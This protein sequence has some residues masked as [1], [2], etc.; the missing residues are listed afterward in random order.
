MRLAATSFAAF[1]IDSAILPCQ[2]RFPAAAAASAPKRPDD[3]CSPGE[4]RS[5]CILAACALTPVAARSS[6]LSS[7][8]AFDAIVHL[9]LLSAR[10]AEAHRVCR[11]GQV[12]E[13]CQSRR[14][15]VASAEGGD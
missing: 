2:R 5:T 7:A 10:S 15:D 14:T 9:I 1:L 12:E 3:R 8:V 11:V 6:A 13:G 4:S